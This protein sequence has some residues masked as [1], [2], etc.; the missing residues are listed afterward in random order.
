MSYISRD[1]LGGKRWKLL[2]FFDFQPQECMLPTY[3]LDR[4]GSPQGGVA[5]LVLAGVEVIST[6]ILVEGCAQEVLVR[7]E[8][9]R[10]Q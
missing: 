5:I 6:R 10:P 7:R 8:Q 4:M 2:G 9:S 3:W 1:S